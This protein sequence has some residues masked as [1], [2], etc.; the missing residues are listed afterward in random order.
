VVQ[1][2]HATRVRRLRIHRATQAATIVAGVALVAATLSFAVR[3]DIT[4]VLGLDAHPI[5]TTS[6]SVAELMETTGVPL[7]V[8]LQVEPPPA[9]VLADGMT[10]TVSPPPG[11][12][13]GALSGT[14]TPEG[15]GVWVVERSSSEPNGKAAPVLDV[16]PA[17]EVG[18]GQNQVVAVHA[19]VFGKV[20]DVLTNADSTG[21]LLS[22]MGIQPGASDRVAPSP[23]T[24][25]HDGDTVRIDRIE[26]EVR[27][28]T[29]PIPHGVVTTYHA[30]MV[31][32]TV[33]VVQEGRDGLRRERVRVTYVNGIET[34]S[35][36]VSA[37]VLRGP[38]DEIRE[39][40][41]M[42]MYE[43]TLSE[44]G[45]GAT[46]QTGQATWYDPPWSGFSAAHPWLPFGTQ[47]VVTDLDS[48]RSVTVTID[49]RGPFA[50]GRIID[51]SPEAFGALAPLGRGV[52]RV[53]LTW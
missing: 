51:L 4:L 38:I 17:S 32:G 11:L 41:P 25:L 19:V 24:P 44:P 20:H 10:V 6:S 12:P 28:R 33:R 49:D 52:L 29:T 46:T 47:V 26:T 8:G 36:V 7:S 2:V 23:D 18:A 43:G 39:S 27:H 35:T 53:S 3:K 21:S 14:V 50:P 45:T 42:S 5:S 31:P 30:D 40:G 15:V 34:A 9:T 16:A 1:A 37:T 13:A 22:A 48:G